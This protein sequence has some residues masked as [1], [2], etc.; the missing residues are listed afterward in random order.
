VS[1]FEAVSQRLGLAVSDL[2]LQA[3][4]ALLACGSIALMPQYLDWCAR[5]G[6]RDQSELLRG[7]LDAAS[8]FVT[9]DIA[10]PPESLLGA[11]EAATPSGPT[12]VPGFTAAQDCWICADS[13][14]RVSIGQFTVKDAVWY[15]LE[16]LFQATSERLFGVADVGSQSQE[17]AEAVALTDPALVAAVD[18]LE[19]VK[20][21][22]ASRAS[23]RKSDVER[24]TATLRLISP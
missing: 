17:S 18:A 3:Q 19:S 7:A 24:T 9:G 15:L 13:A 16:P 2:S 21:D 22:L 14:I 1:P 10:V 20:R 8:Q 4:V 6:A 11:M 12:D 23:L 5:S